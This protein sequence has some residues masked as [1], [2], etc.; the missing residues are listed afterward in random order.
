MQSLETSEFIRHEACEH[1]GSSDARS[2][3]ILMVIATALVVTIG[4]LVTP[5]LF[6]HI[7]TFPP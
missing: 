3:C 7:L 2:L 1:C 6:P 4:V 5:L